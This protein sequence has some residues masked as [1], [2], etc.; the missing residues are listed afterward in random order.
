MTDD[1][2][3]IPLPDYLTHW[4]ATQRWFADKGRVP[5]L[6]SIGSWRL[7]SDE[8]EAD[9]RTELVFDEA[10]PTRTLYQLPLVRRTTPLPGGE[11][12]LISTRED[13]SAVYDGT[14]DPA[15]GRAL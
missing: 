3:L 10:A 13:G 7:P 2:R 4:V 1:G 6:V 14:A 5:R 11:Q 15:Y 8:A 12:A 9:I